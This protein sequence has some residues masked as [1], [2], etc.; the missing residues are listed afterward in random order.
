MI[1][2]CGYYLERGCDYG[3]IYGDFDLN[4]ILGAY[5]LAGDD[6]SRTMVCRKK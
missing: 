2:A 5:G 6:V 4:R 1:T 3:G